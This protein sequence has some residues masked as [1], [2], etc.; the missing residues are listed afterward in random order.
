MNGDTRSEQNRHM[1]PYTAGMIL[2]KYLVTIGL[3]HGSSLMAANKLSSDLT[4]LP[5][6]R[7][8]DVIVQFTHPPSGGDNECRRFAGRQQSEKDFRSIHGLLVTLPVAALKGI[9]DIPG[10]VWISLGSP[11]CRRTGIRGTDRECQH[12]TSVR[13]ERVG[14]RRCRDRQRNLQ[15]IPI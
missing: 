3:L 8:V 15:T 13:M 9:S 6:L 10:V 14:Y 5:P 1:R 12:R 11:C 2:L 4:G 7:F